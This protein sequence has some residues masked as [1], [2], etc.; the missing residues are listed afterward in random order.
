MK[1]TYVDPPFHP[2]IFQIRL[3]TKMHNLIHFTLL[4]FPTEF[5][6]QLDKLESTV[7]EWLLKN[8]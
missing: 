3:P 4:Y 5:V 7:N 2:D 8:N 6:E 1:Y